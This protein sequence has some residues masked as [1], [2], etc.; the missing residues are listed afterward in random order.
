VLAA[1]LADSARRQRL[2]ANGLERAR[3]LTWAATATSILGVYASAAT[4]SR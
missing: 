2:G 1:L 4:S 3:G